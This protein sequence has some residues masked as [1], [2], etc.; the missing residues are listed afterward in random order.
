MWLRESYFQPVGQRTLSNQALY[1][2]CDP[3]FVIYT[4]MRSGT[5]SMINYVRNRAEMIAMSETAKLIMSE[6]DAKVLIQGVC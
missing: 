2:G 1:H 4:D 6:I 3:L 5:R